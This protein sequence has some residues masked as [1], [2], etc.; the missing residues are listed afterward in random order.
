MKLHDFGTHAL[1]L[2]RGSTLPLASTK[3]YGLISADL[4]EKRRKKKKNFSLSS[5]S[6]ALPL[7]FSSSYLF[8]FGFFFLHGA[9]SIS[10]SGPFLPRNNLF[11]FSSI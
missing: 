9:M 2:M 8:D 3:T 4:R 6:P 7:P 11:I 10:K 5:R 1:L